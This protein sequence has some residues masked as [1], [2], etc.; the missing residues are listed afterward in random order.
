MK[1]KISILSIMAVLLSLAFFPITNVKAA[2]FKECKYEHKEGGNDF[3]DMAYSIVGEFEVCPEP[4]TDAQGKGHSFVLTEWNSTR[5][6]IEAVTENDE[7]CLVRRSET[8]YH[9]M[10]V[11]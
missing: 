2:G 11:W 6:V 8:V 3:L 7:D 10:N 5:I 1:Q 9:D 4:A